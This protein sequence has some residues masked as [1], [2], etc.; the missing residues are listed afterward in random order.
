MDHGQVD[1]ASPTCTPVTRLNT[2]AFT[3]LDLN[4]FAFTGLEC[5]TGLEYL[6]SHSNL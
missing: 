4:T 2:F 1:H 3:G 5:R 6:V